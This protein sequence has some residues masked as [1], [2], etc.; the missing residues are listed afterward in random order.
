MDEA[1]FHELARQV[2]RYWGA[3]LFPRVVDQGPARMDWYYVSVARDQLLKG[4]DRVLHLLLHEWG[5]RTISPANIEQGIAWGV[6]L[7]QEGMGS[8]EAQDLVNI[9]A[10]VWVDDRYLSLDPWKELY[11][12]S[13]TR[14]VGEIR[15]QLAQDRRRGDFP[16]AD[17]VLRFMG[18][19]Y[20]AMLV[21]HGYPPPPGGGGKGDAPA[22]AGRRAY[23]ALTD[24]LSPVE[25]R[26]RALVREGGRYVADL[27]R[28]KRLVDLLARW[29]RSSI[30][31]EDAD[32]PLDLSRLA[33]L[34]R[35]MRVK[36]ETAGNSSLV[37]ARH[38]RAL[39]ME[40]RKLELYE[41][42]VTPME[43]LLRRRTP[44]ERC[45]FQIW[46]AGMPMRWLLVEE[47]IQ[48]H[49]EVL[50]NVTTLRRA[51]RNRGPESSA[52]SAA[53]VCCVIDDSGSTSG[54]AIQREQEASFAVIQTAR[55]KRDLF[56]VVV[57]GTRVTH[58]MEP[59]FDYLAG[60]D[61]ICSLGG[62]SGGT[63]LLPALQQAL[64]YSERGTS[65]STLVFTD[66]GVYDLEDC[67]P[68]MEV[69]ARR[70]RLVLFCFASSAEV[71]AFRRKIPRRANPTFFNSVL[72]LLSERR[73]TFRDKVF[74]SP[75]YIM[76]L[77]RNPH[78]EASNEI[79]RAFMDRIDFGFDLPVM[80]I[81]ETLR[82]YDRITVR[83][84][85]HWGSLEHL[86]P[87][88]LRVEELVR[89]WAAVQEVAI[90]IRQRVWACMLSDAFR[91]CIKQ[92]RSELSPDFVLNCAD[93]KFQAEI[94]A[95]LQQIPGHRFTHSTLRLAQA[96]AWLNGQA[97]VSEEDITWAL[98]YTLAHRLVLK[99]E[100]MRQTPSTAQWLH[101][102]ACGE[103]LAN[104]EPVWR[105]A[106]D[107]FMA[108]DAAA[109]ERTW[110][111]DLV[112]QTMFMFMRT[113]GYRDFITP[114]IESGPKAK[115]ERLRAAPP[116]GR[117]RK[118]P[119]PEGQAPPVG[120]TPF[121]S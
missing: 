22:K 1:R 102:T 38:R 90:D 66:T 51:H 71:A 75:G 9:A 59:G 84:K 12:R 86:A 34:L 100:L 28:L 19:I 40:V 36:S 112:I 98:P 62:L 70:G 77:D 30:L 69:L 87:A 31:P 95:H 20:E 48:R 116:R 97:R 113:E 13:I 76:F 117:H 45:G 93:C 25:E 107:G 14:Q 89:I 82:L 92:E 63:A 119:G 32:L 58:A 55:R 105:A 79:P 115:V 15:E 41:L 52:G 60:E 81:D 53:H 33:R 121:R 3:H 16:Y 120:A 44:R 61:L 108:G 5:H 91:L 73:V 47:T 99:P 78:D 27:N 80:H 23:A 17:K 42:V 88:V 109:L 74:E 8:A 54:A 68:A 104:K 96:R 39:A 56:S 94:C 35:Q 29:G 85:L 57:F 106:L 103:I 2:N 49:G 46:N 10:D 65:T 114:Y 111:Q 67:L 4:D 83:Q 50:A 118:G 24:P 18:G 43:R 7:E 72:P 110:Q 26:L 21:A 64:A 6:F 11:A 37:P 101:K